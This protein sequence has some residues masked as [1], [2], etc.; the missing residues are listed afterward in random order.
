M[1]I[2]RI[3]PTTIIQ[4]SLSTHDNYS[5]P[6]QQDKVSKPDGW[7]M[8]VNSSFPMATGD[9]FISDTQLHNLQRDIYCEVGK[10]FH[11]LGFRYDY[12]INELW[13]NIYSKGQGQE[14]HSHLSHLPNK[15]P[16]WSGIYYYKN[17]S[18]SSTTFHRSDFAYRTQLF[19]GCLDTAIADAYYENWQP[20]VSDGDVILFPP[21]LAHNVHN[22]NDL[23]RITFAFNVDVM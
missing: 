10:V 2:H 9:D 19:D 15:N 20:Y 3:F 23:Q 14:I 11:E 4:F 13:Y 7:T 5:F 17:C 21:H 22:P 12:E 18:E 1:K 6:Y 16:I 8:P